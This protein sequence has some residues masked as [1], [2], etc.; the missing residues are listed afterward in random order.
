MPPGAARGRKQRRPLNSRGFPCVG[1][2]SMARAIRR[3]VDDSRADVLHLLGRAI[4]TGPTSVPFRHGIKSF[5]AVDFPIGR[6]PGRLKYT[7]HVHRILCVSEGI[8]QVLISCGIPPELAE[9]VHSGIDLSRFET[10]TDAAAV[11]REFS[12]AGVDPLLVSVAALTDH[13]G[14]AYLLS[15]M[16]RVWQQ[17]RARL[18][19]AGEGCGRRWRVNVRSCTWGTR[20]LLGYRQDVPTYWRRRICSCCLRTWKDCARRFWTRWRCACRW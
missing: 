10:A 9:T 8:R 3:I 5:A 11:R 2:S 6:G 17:F 12:M 7:R 15:A 14:H 16:P 19:I 4:G 20:W 13:K 18:L 1:S